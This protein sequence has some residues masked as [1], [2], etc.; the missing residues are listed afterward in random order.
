MTDG[1]LVDVWQFTVVIV[2]GAVAM[3]ALESR[4]KD[5]RT[6]TRS[7]VALWLRS[8]IPHPS[9][10]ILGDALTFVLGRGAS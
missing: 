9:P 5:Q 3:G 6:A 8:G 10:R 4:V 7:R 1:S 2:V